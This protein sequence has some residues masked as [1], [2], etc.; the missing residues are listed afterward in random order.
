MLLLHRSEKE[1]H[2][3]ISTTTGRYGKVI[4]E[5]ELVYNLGRSTSEDDCSLH[6]DEY[7]D[8]KKEGNGS[9]KRSESNNTNQKHD[10]NLF[11][12]EEAKH[13]EVDNSNFPINLDG[14]LC[15]GNMNEYM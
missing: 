6:S 9:K 3:S 1:R 14:V 2:N 11:K 7:Y 12:M 13:H 15:C 10:I 5:V 4:D 8:Q